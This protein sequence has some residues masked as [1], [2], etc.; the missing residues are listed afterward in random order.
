[1]NTIV[2][3]MFKTA[4]VCSHYR[5]HE[6]RI[7]DRQD[8]H[9]GGATGQLQI[10]N[11]GLQELSHTGL[12]SHPYSYDRETSLRPPSAVSVSSSSDSAAEANSLNCS[13]GDGLGSVSS[14]TESVNSWSFRF[15]GIPS[16]ALAADNAAEEKSTLLIDNRRRTQDIISSVDATRNSLLQNV[17][18]HPQVWLIP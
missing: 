14:I 9:H 6:C 18:P 13:V 1:M 3:D 7:A 4:Y 5:S 12:A 11:I 2:A 8:R 10:P 15:P 16:D 17:H